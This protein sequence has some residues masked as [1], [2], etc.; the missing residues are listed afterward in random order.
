MRNAALGICLIMTLCGATA[1]Q[2]TETV[3]YAFNGSPDGSAPSGGLE[4]DSAG[5]IY[6]TTVL[7]GTHCLAQGGCGTVYELTPSANGYTE[8]VLYTFCTTG[9]RYTCPDG[10]QPLGGLILDKS[11]N[12]FGTT[13]L[14]G[15]G[16]GTVFELSP[17]VIPGGAWT[18]TVL[19]AFGGH[20]GD[21]AGPYQGK[22]NRDAAGNLYGTTELGGSHGLG[23]VFELTPNG[24]GGWNESVLV[25]FSGKNGSNPQY[26]VAIDQLGNLYGT[27]HTGGVVNS[28]CSS[29]CGTVYELMPTTKGWTGRI[30]YA[31]TG[32]DGGYPTSSISID[33]HGNLYGTLA[34]RGMSGCYADEGCGAVFEL[35]PN[36]HGGFNRYS[37]L[38]D[39]QGNDGGNPFGG[40]LVD[41]QTGALYGTTYGGNNV[42]ELNHGAETVLY[43]FCSQPSCA[44][45]TSPSA[46]T[47]VSRD[48]LLYG[49]T[50]S[51]GNAYN[52]VV[53]SVTK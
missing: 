49:V 38:F 45:G 30:L 20:K 2:S 21:G 4:F 53:Y 35:A 47:L 50:P 5:N 11:G 22:L 33:A 27:A 37:F 28:T 25:S 12:L 7:G 43:Q 51:G 18:E 32:V 19:W 24:N 52:G 9:N 1:A 36:H 46:G 10:A 15:R 3:L 41:N 23:T 17:P 42:Y 8:S 40:V 48:G 31:P 29:G 26:G 14:G 13:S 6:G 39:G 16:Q 34:Y 44:D